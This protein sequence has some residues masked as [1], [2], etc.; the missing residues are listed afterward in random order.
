MYNEAD[1]VM[2]WTYRAAVASIFDVIRDN[3]RAYVAPQ[4][5][6]RNGGGRGMRKAMNKCSAKGVRLYTTASG[7]V[8]D[9]HVAPT[10]PVGP[11]DS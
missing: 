2:Q 8:S 3:K 5:Y 9:D 10:L 1:Q 4:R 11:P 7:K 6:E